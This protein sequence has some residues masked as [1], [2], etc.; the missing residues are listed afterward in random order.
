MGY[1]E[2]NPSKLRDVDRLLQK[3][4]GREAWLYEQVC[5]KYGVAVSA[6]KSLSSSSSAAPQPAASADSAASCSGECSICL[7]EFRTGEA[8]LELPCEAKH[9]FHEK[10]LTQWLS[11]SVVC[12]L[13][14]VDVK[15]RLPPSR[16]T[17]GTGGLGNV[18]RRALSVPR[19][20]APLLGSSNSLGRTAAGGSVLRYEQNPPPDWE[21]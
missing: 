20:H 2:H 12:P 6:S 15:A 13:C 1:R 17:R 7:A 10:C 3:H 5:A 21:R 11:K 4:K 18:G 16:I 14:R 9:R 8:L 19:R